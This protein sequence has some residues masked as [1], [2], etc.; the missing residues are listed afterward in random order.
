MQNASIMARAVAAT[1]AAAIMSSTIGSLLLI[2]VPIVSSS[3]SGTE[4][5]AANLVIAVAG[6]LFLA[7]MGI[8]WGLIWSLPCAALLG[9]IFEFPKAWWFSATNGHRFLHFGA[10]IVAA[11]VL[12]TILPGLGF[13]GDEGALLPLVGESWPMHLVLFA[14]GGLSSACAWWLLVVLPWR[15]ARNRHEAGA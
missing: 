9:L 7:V 4:T 10:S 14:V 2:S 11:L 6:F 8:G 12:G 3:V 1:L 15:A 13:F 5:P